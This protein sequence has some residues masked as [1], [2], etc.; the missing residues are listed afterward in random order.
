MQTAFLSGKPTSKVISRKHSCLGTIFDRDDRRCRLETNRRARSRIYGAGVF[1][2]S[3]LFFLHCS[4]LDPPQIPGKTGRPPS[5]S[6][7]AKGWI[8]HKRT[9]AVDLRMEAYITR[10]RS[11][12]RGLGTVFRRGTKA[13]NELVVAHVSE[14]TS[15]EDFRLFLR[16]LHRSGVTARADVVFLFASSPLPTDMTDLIHQEDDYFRELLLSTINVSSSQDLVSNLSQARQT[17]SMGS[18]RFSSNATISPFNVNAFKKAW[19]E[20]ESS[21][22]PLWGS[23]GSNPFQPTSTR[24]ESL[25][26][27]GSLVGFDVSELNPDDAL[28]GFIDR[29]PLHLRRWACYQMLLGMVRHKFKHILLTEV[30][31]AFV[32]RDPLTLPRR[33]VGLYL[34]L[35]DRTWGASMADELGVKGVQSVVD[36]GRNSSGSADNATATGQIQLPLLKGGNGRSST[37]MRRQLRAEVEMRRRAGRRK[38]NRRS[39]A[40]GLY[41]RVYGRRMWS[42]LEEVEKNK[43]LVN[44]GAIVGGIHQIRG[45]ANTMVTEIVKVAL[46]RNN[47]DP[48]PDSVLLSYLLHKSSVL[49]K[50]V[51]EHLHLMDNSE[52]FV[53]SLVGSQQLTLFFNKV[54]QPYSMIHGCSKSRQWDRVASVLARDICLSPADGEVYK[55][56]LRYV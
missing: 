6:E 25:A 31:G 22:Q 37:V 35:E 1:F 18:P 53:H 41:E 10:H 26:G 24:E 32:L 50:R 40:A 34:S 20:N 14:N 8:F 45:L 52:S 15:E 44:S 49:G 47:R 5:V 11:A 43:K 7:V 9:D 36:D 30:G 48:F 54:R 29:P 27:W 56:C 21:L 4:H 42:T 55:D 19:S 46:E 17:P 2:V 28:E 33:K 3:M 23:R 12:L 13:M 38:R 51:V 39:T 16:T